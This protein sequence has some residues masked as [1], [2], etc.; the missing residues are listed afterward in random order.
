M[1]LNVVQLIKSDGHFS[2]IPHQQ[3]MTLSS[4]S[5]NPP[6]KPHIAVLI[7]CYN[8]EVAISK[9]VADFRVSLSDA[10]IY[11]YDNNSKDRT[12]DVAK[13]AGAIVRT[14]SQQGKGHVVR[15]MFRDIEADF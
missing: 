6:M 8:E 13:M 2:Q 14:E 7:P 15:R 11:V 10:V 9:V 3:A 4:S 12:A 1:D 5:Y